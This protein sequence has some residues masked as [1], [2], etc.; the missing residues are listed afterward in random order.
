M[1]YSI[2][3]FLHVVVLVLLAAVAIGCEVDEPE[4]ADAAVDAGPDAAV[5]AGPDAAVDA[6]PDAAVDAGPDAAVDAGPDAGG[7]CTLDEMAC[8]FDDIYICTSVDGW[9]LF[10]DCQTSPNPPDYVC[11]EIDGGSGPVCSI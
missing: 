11:R 6:G 4:T 2:Y 10:Q 7:E 1:K 5:D 9:Q 3:Q 8:M